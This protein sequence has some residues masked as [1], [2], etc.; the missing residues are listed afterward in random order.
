MP[1]RDG[2]GKGPKEQSKVPSKAPSGEHEDPNGPGVERTGDRPGLA[3]DERQLLDGFYRLAPEDTVHWAFEDT[4][5]RLSNPDERATWIEPWD[6][7]PPDLWDRGRLAKAGERAFGDVIKR[8]AQ[9]LTEYT[10]RIVDDVR[11]T[12]PEETTVSAALWQLAARLERLESLADPTGIRPAELDLPAPDAGEWVANIPLWL[13]TPTGLPVVIGE[14]GVRP[15]LDA[16]V[17]A[18][19]P[20][21]VVDPRGVVAWALGEAPPGDPGQVSVAMGEVTDHLSGLPAD[22][23]S[24]VV[25]SGCVDRIALAGKVD[26]MD[27][28]LR[29]LTPG[30][31]LVVL[32]VDQVAWDADLAPSVRDLLPGRPF[33]PETW[34]LVLEHRGFPAP[35]VHLASNGTVH[36]IVARTTG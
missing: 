23:R 35:E 19:A 36:A 13:G 33:H 9:E 22:S 11:R 4:M 7:L 18:G 20:V 32:T 25:L 29:A 31:A 28:A 34:A 24:G 27:A 1:E 3:E 21:D 16:V 26:L 8:V 5:R 10:Q 14:A 17:A 6:G 2:V 15:V 12:T 30:G